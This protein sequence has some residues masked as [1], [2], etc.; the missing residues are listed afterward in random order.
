MVLDVLR[1][2]AVEGRGRAGGVGAALAS[3]GVVREGAS[4]GR[5]VQ[6]TSPFSQ[7]P[8]NVA[9]GGDRRTVME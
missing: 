2:G 1:F 6:G 7:L 3:A 5:A 9:A 4:A 8:D